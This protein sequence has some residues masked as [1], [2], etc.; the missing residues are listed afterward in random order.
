MI[1]YV[2]SSSKFSGASSDFIMEPMMFFN[3]GQKLSLSFQGTTHSQNISMM[4]WAEHLNSM[5]SSMS[6]NLLSI[7]KLE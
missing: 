2:S 1:H 6:L 3:V 7:V 5:N 4:Q